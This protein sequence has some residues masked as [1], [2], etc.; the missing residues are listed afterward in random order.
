MTRET[1]FQLPDPSFEQYTWVL[2]DEHGPSSLP[3]L[4][5]YDDGYRPG[6]GGVPGNLRIHGFNYVRTS[7]ERRRPSWAASAPPIAGSVEDLRRWRTDW[8]PEVENVVR[9]LEGF[10]PATVPPGQWAQTLN[11][12]E[13]QYMWVFGGIHRTAPGPAHGAYLAFADAFRKRFG[14][15]RD[16]DLHALL[17]GVDNCSLDR[18]AALW[19]LSRILRANP[20]LLE[21]LDRGAALPETPE[22]RSF[23]DAF[24]AMIATYGH[25]SNNDLQDLPVWRED[26]DIPMA[27]VRAYARQDDDASPRNA[28]ARQRERRLE[29]EAE[30]QHMA[31]A[32]D[33]QVAQVLA[34]L[35]AA[36]EFMPNIEDHNFFADQRQIAASRHRWMSIGRHLQDR[37]LIDAA[38][39]VFFIEA[40][41]LI[42]VLEGETTPDRDAVAERKRRLRVARASSPPPVLGRPLERAEAGV[43]DAA[44]AG[45]A[46]AGMRTLRGVAASPGSFRGRARVI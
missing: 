46:S 2:Q 7:S 12:Q 37:G 30:L 4:L 43:E 9:L 34:I 21:A 35:A 29:L 36:Q 25:T 11:A 3:P 26:P 17:Q 15:E 5:I 14:R 41:E 28:A 42:P 33:A 22:A 31:D 45:L 23:D 19:D 44:P 24:A 1:V 40:R 10:D 16:E 32:G 38:D 6:P 39:D 18:A 20:E 13:E 8:L 27:A